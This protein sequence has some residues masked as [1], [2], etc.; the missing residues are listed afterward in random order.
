M[1]VATEHS[2]AGTFKTI[3]VPVKLSETPGAVYRAAPAL[4]EHTAEILTSL[5]A[6]SRR[7]R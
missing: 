2:R 5:P 4:G 6:K 7:S 1:Y 3:G